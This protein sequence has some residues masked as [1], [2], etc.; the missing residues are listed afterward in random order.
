VTIPPEIIVVDAVTNDR[1]CDATMTGTCC[2]PRT[3]GTCD[4]RKQTF[5][6]FEPSGACTYGVVEPEPDGG[7]STI[8]LLVGRCTLFVSKPGFASAVE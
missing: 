6:S 8:E 7:G 5:R 3:D 2:Y 1:I 4:F